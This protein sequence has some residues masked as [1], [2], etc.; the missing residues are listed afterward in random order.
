M[1]SIVVPAGVHSATSAPSQALE[2]LLV[3]PPTVL[4]VAAALRVCDHKS[5]GRA[6]FESTTLGRDGSV[7][8]CAL[9]GAM[10]HCEPE[11]HPADADWYRPTLATMLTKDSFVDYE[12]LAI[13]V[14]EIARAIAWCH[15][16][17]KSETLTRLPERDALRRALDAVDAAAREVAGLAVTTSADR[18]GPT[19]VALRDEEAAA[20]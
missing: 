18:L 14:R 15:E 13:G 16:Q 8:W 9:C 20:L 11:T 10:A 1:Q 7:H 3:E 6:S 5:A 4:S 19:Y 12:Q 17:A 2:A